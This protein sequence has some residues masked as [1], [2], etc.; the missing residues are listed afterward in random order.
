MDRPDG[1]APAAG[2][3][4]AADLHGNLEHQVDIVGVAAETLRR[5]NPDQPGLP[6]VGDGLVGYA[7]QF[8]CFDGPLLKHRHESLRPIEQLFAA[9]DL[10]LY[11][12]VRLFPSTAVSRVCRQ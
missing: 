12:H 9:Y 7:T 10:L 4:A 3:A 8:F 2:T 5:G 6:E 1:V 11:C